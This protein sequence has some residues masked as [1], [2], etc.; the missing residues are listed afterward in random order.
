MYPHQNAEARAPRALDHTTRSIMPRNAYTACVLTAVLCDLCDPHTGAPVVTGETPSQERGG[1]HVACHTRNAL[2]ANA[3][4]YACTHRPGYSR[5]CL[6][7]TCTSRLKHFLIRHPAPN[8]LCPVACMAQPTS[9]AQHAILDP[10]LCALISPPCPKRATAP[11]LS[12]M[13]LPCLH[14]RSQSSSC[15]S[16]FVRDA[17]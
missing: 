14:Q 8:S 15:P 1:D 13:P 5:V 4:A 17:T 16:S 11:T 9:A 6:A 7:S 3:N 2:H 10:Y 12:H